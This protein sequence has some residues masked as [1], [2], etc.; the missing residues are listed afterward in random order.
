MMSLLVRFSMTQG[1]IYSLGEDASATGEQT[2]FISVLEGRNRKG[3]KHQESSAAPEG[4]EALLV[5]LLSYV[6]GVVA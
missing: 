3:K 6:R 5:R 2:T 1:D 4:P